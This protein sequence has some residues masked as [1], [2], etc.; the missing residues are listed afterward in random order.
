MYDHKI[1]IKDGIIYDT[2]DGCNKQY[3]CANALWILSVS[4][5]T[6]RVI[7]DSCN[8]APGNVIRKINCING[9]EKS[10]LRQKNVHDRH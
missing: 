5:F 7:I 10:Y 2:T 6:Y 8:N 9:S 3:R 1:S 4:E